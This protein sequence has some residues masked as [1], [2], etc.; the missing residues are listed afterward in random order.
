MIN[1]TL[2]TASRLVNTL[3][4]TVNTLSFYETKSFMNLKWVVNRRV[5]NYIGRTH[6]P[7]ILHGKR[8]EFSLNDIRKF[9]NLYDTNDVQ[10]PPIQFL[11]S[12]LSNPIKQL[13]E[14]QSDINKTFRELKNIQSIAVETLKKVPKIKWSE[15]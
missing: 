1:E 8:I 4:R 14:Q 7:L 12:K 6:M 5:H 11:V 3:R 2:Y 10:T 13:T 15:V 9:L